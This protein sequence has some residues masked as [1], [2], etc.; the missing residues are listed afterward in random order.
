MIARHF[1]QRPVLLDLA[2][3]R[4]CHELV[5]LDIL[6]MNDL[7]L[8]G[9]PQACAL[10]PVAAPALV[11]SPSHRTTSEFSRIRVVSE[12]QPQQVP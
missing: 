10:Q 6:E 3:H 8:I 2:V 9:V 11:F 1:I 4:N 7:M 5:R 12:G